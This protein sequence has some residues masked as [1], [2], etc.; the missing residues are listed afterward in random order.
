MRKFNHTDMLET[1]VS[2]VYVAGFLAMFTF[3]ILAVVNNI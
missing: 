3:T 1:I 2:V